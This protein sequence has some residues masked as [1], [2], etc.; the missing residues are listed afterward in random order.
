MEIASLVIS[1]LAFLLSIIAFIKS[2]SAANT[3]N[4]LTKGQVEMQIREMIT[5]AKSRYAD[6]AIQHSK[7]HDNNTLQSSTLSALED[8][9]NAYDEACAKYIDNKVDKI[10]FKKLYVNEIRNIVKDENTK[11]K[12]QMPQSRFQATVTVYREWNNLE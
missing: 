4:A 2:S 6:L 9:M 8:V 5:S 7:D 3:A 11:D 12:F 10:R 1:I